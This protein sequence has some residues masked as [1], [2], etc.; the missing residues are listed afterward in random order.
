MHQNRDLE[1]HFS[2]LL[3]KGEELVWAGRPKTGIRF[4]KSD[5]I[6]IPFSI[7]WGGFSIFWV[8]FSVA[9]GAPLIFTA[10]GFPFVL[11]GL[12][13][14]IGRFFFDA[15]RRKN[16]VYG[17]TTLH[18]IRKV[19]NKTEV[20]PLENLPAITIIKHNDGSGTID[21]TDL[22]QFSSRRKTTVSVPG[23]QTAS[24]LEMIPEPETVYQLIL[25]LQALRKVDGALHD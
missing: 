24:R 14:M 7:V 18:I 15:Y 21:F 12:Y 19:G 6:L 23:F 2:N 20:F 16:T 10:F 5:M 13:M 22:N 11:I 9:M 3:V 1:T 8:A 17:I 4:R 25:D